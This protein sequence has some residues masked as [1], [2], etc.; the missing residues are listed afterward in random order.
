MQSVNPA[1]EGVHQLLQTAG[2]ILGPHWQTGL[3]N[4]QMLS[5]PQ[6]ITGM[7]THQSV[8]VVLIE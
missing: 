7:F 6:A 1:S 8:S 3:S 5:I 2:S 4:E